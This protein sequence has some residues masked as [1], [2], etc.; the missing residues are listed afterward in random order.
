MVVDSDK[1][2]EVWLLKVVKEKEE[3]CMLVCDCH[4]TIEES[5]VLTFSL[6]SHRRAGFWWNQEG[7]VL[8]EY[9]HIC[10]KVQVSLIPW[11]PGAA[12]FSKTR[13][14]YFLRK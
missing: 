12:Y 4:W 5:P 9:N 10:R 6:G 3:G 14:K 8:V 11:N 7:W 13:P 1:E 2:K